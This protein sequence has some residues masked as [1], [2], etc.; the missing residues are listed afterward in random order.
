GLLEERARADV[1][2]RQIDLASAIV[3]RVALENGSPLRLRE[4]DRTREEGV[5]DALAAMAR[6][7]ADAPH[8]PCVLIIDVRDLPAVRERGLRAWRDGRPADHGIAL[9]REDTDRPL[10]HELPGLRRT[11]LTAQSNVLLRREAVAQAPADV[12]VGT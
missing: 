10:G 11:R 1:R 3:D 8:G 12:R 2:H 5:R 9:V 4:V 7:H 6:A